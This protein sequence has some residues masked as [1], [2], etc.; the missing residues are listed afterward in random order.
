MSEPADRAAGAVTVR[1][2]GGLGNQLFQYAAGRAAA[3][4]LGVDLL[5]DTGF[6]AATRGSETHREFA[7]QWLVP[8]EDVV[9][10]TTTGMLGRV[11]DRLRRT[12]HRE[13]SPRVFTEAGYSYDPRI[14]DVAPGSTVIGYFQSW[15]YFEAI[16]PALRNDVLA[17]APRSSWFTSTLEQLDADGPWTA[18]H[19]RRGDYLLAR[20]AAYHGLLSPDYYE[21]ALAQIDPAGSHRL[22]A[23]SDDP[24][25]VPGVLRE[26]A[27]DAV[28]IDPPSQSS[29]ME[30]LALMSRASA[31]VTANSSFS[32]WGAWLA[33]P[34]ASVACPLPWLHGAGL[35]EGDL[36]P[37]WWQS[38]GSDFEVRRC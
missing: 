8:S 30:S 10:S 9:R 25:S 35:D 23:F 28:I 26:R 24:E 36:R 11:G 1:L 14:L 13:C 20:N 15:R 19:I 34:Q 31:I 2:M 37:P 29:P 3:T 22:V 17:A 38:V 33:G 32:W 27:D 16:A 21:R 6:L 5:V 4:R 18:V 7:L 12:L